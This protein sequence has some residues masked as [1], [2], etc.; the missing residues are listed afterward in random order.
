MF[1]PQEGE[2]MNRESILWGVPPWGGPEIKIA[3]GT[4]RQMIAE[5]RSRQRQGWDEFAIRP[6]V[7]Q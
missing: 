3:A 1:Q 5:Q 6:A 4:L 7:K 2:E